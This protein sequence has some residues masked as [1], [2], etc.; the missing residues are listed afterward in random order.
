TGAIATQVPE[1]AIFELC[2]LFK[3]LKE[4]DKII[5]NALVEPMTGILA[6][7][8]FVLF[9][10]GE[11]GMRNFATKGKKIEKPSDLKGLKM[12]AQESWVHEEMYRVNGG[13]PVQMPVSEVSSSLATGNIDGFDNTPLF[14]FAAQWYK[15]IDTWIVSDH[16]YQPAMIVYNKDW[17]DSL[18]DDLKT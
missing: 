2:G 7:N 13:N 17:Y 4:A 16:I 15:N 12:R 10:M 3:D 9:T 18:P 5:D 11:N 1:A 14:A 6:D 8:G